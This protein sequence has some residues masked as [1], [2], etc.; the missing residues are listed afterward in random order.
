MY[1]FTQYFP[2]FVND[3]ASEIEVSVDWI[4]PVAEFHSILR[5][6]D[7]IFRVFFIILFFFAVSSSAFVGRVFS[8][9]GQ[10]LGRRRRRCAHRPTHPRQGRRPPPPKIKQKQK[11]SDC[12]KKTNLILGQRRRL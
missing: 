5:D 11:K 1:S 10:R 3:F 2:V 6:F 12:E 4:W 8:G 9:G 7:Q